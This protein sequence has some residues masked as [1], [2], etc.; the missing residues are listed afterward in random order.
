MTRAATDRLRGP[1]GGWYRMPGAAW[2]SELQQLFRAV[3]W[4][5]RGIKIRANALGTLPF[6][7]RDRA[8]AI[9][10]DSRRYRNSAGMMPNPRRLLFAIETSLT[11]TRAAYLWPA[12]D[13]AG[14]VRDL[15]PLATHTIK[16]LADSRAGLVG[17]ERTTPQGV[18]R[19]EPDEIIY[20][21]SEDP[22]SEI[23]PGTTS[24]AE[25]ALR[26][27]RVI[28][29]LSRFESAFFESGA[30]KA[31]LLTVA[32]NPPAA[33]KNR[34]AEWWAQF[35]A[36]VRSAFGAAVINADMIK[37]VVIGQGLEGLGNV[38]L[39]AEK[40]ADIAVALGIPGGM[41][42]SGDIPAALAHAHDRRLYRDTVIPESL[43]I[44]DALNEQVFRPA[45]YRLQ[46]QPERLSCFTRGEAARSGAFVTYAGAGMRPSVAAEML[47][48]M[49]PEG[50]TYES[51][52]EAEERHFQRQ[53]ELYQGRW[54]A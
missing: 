49:L 35:V 26:S 42:Q 7:V 50:V 3:P 11:L 20:I 12:R 14:R 9:V 39:T 48:L 34:I 38:P 43:C 31:T 23:G 41:L 33:E 37:P 51:L 52:N 6:V 4:L 10:D 53:A 1:R 36:G 16:P 45:G 24:P 25:V 27:A 46:F 47:G 18:E 19:W 30:V 2:P 32:G 40:R 8:G 15:V 22:L 5:S 17:L 29:E 13:Q 28:F 44:A 54:G 21:W